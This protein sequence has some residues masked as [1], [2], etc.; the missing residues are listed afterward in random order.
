MDAASFAEMDKEALRLQIKLV[1]AQLGLDRTKVSEN[2][3]QMNA[4][5]EEH[6]KSDPLIH[7]MDKKANPW[8]EKGKCLLM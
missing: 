3:K 8:V 4:Y 6:E 5:V 2:I 7:P 1:T